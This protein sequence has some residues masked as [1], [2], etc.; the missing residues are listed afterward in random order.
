M[1]RSTFTIPYHCSFEKAQQLLESYLINE[2]FKFQKIN[3][4]EYVWKKGLGALTNDKYIKVDYAQNLITLSA[5]I[6]IGV[7][8]GGSGEMDL[9]GFTL[10]VPKKQLLKIIEKTKALF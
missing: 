4:G 6:Q 2:G 8:S 10:A 5:W 7:G 1:S 3:T 9:T